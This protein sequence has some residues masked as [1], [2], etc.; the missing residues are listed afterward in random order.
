MFHRCYAYIRE[1]GSP[2]LAEPD[3]VARVHGLL[4]R[5]LHASA[6]GMAMMTGLGPAVP[7]DGGLRLRVSPPSPAREAL[8]VVQY[9]SS[10][11]PAAM[12][13]GTREV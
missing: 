4:R 13:K 1:G 8:T 11:A 12:A 2:D 5:K 7:V 9:L 3:G 6:M 10:S